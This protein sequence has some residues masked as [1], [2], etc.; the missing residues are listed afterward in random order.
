MNTIEASPFRSLPRGREIRNYFSTS[1]SDIS[2][3]VRAEMAFGTMDGAKGMISEI[4]D[5]LE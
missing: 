1:A 5:W 3:G 2:T 4:N